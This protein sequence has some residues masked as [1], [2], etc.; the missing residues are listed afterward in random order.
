MIKPKMFGITTVSDKGQVVL[1]AEARKELGFERGDK[2]IVLSGQYRHMLV[3][4]KPSE[5]PSLLKVLNKELKS[6]SNI[7]EGIE[8]EEK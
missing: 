8:D 3:L 7:L 6:A 2:L 5:I 4:I 1:P